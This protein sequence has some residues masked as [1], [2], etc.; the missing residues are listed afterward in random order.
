[1]CTTA[2]VKIRCKIRSCKA[3]MI[4][5][6]NAHMHVQSFVSDILIDFVVKNVL[7]TSIISIGNIFLM[8]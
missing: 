6:L 3:I 8:Q 7:S 1:M 5:V 4:T 2:H